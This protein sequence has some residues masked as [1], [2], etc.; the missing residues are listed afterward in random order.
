M[1][2]INFG[3]ITYKYSIVFKEAHSK[4]VKEAHGDIHHP[5]E[6]FQF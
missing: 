6:M 2:T 1:I 5:I 4:R 3:D